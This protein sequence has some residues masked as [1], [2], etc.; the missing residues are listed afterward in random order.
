MLA[1]PA[2]AATRARCDAGTGSGPWS[3]RFWTATAG[4]CSARCR[5]RSA[6]ARQRAA[7]TPR[8]CSTPRRHGAWTGTFATDD[9]D[10]RRLAVRVAPDAHGVIALRV[11]VT[12]S[13]R[14]RAVEATG[15]AFRARPGERYLG[16]G[17]RSNSVDQRGGEVENYVAEGPYEEDDQ[18]DHP[19]VRAR[20]GLPPAP[21]RHLLP[22]ALAALHRRL[23]RAGGRPRDELLPPRPGRERGL[24]RGGGGGAPQPARVRR[25]AP[26]RRPAPLHRARRPPARG[27][28][29]VLLRAL[30]PARAAPSRRRCSRGC[31][32]ATRRCPWPRPTPTTCPCADQTGR[33]EAERARVAGFHDAGLAVTTYFNPMICTT[34]PRYG[35]A[36]ADGALVKNPAGE[37]YVYRY[38]TLTTLRRRRSST[39]PARAGRDLYGQLLREA[40]ADG[41]DGWMED[42]GEYTPLDARRGRRHRPAPALHNVYPRQ[43]HC[44]AFAGVAGCAARA[45]ALRRARAGPAARAARRSCGAATRRSGWGFDGLRSVVT[46]GLTMGLS[47]VSTWGSDIGGFFALFG[48]RLDPGAAGPL[49]RGGRGVR[50]DAHAGQRDQHPGAAARP[51][52]GR[53]GAAALAPLGQAA[54]AALPLPRRG[55]RGV[56]PQRS[57]DHAPPRAGL[58]RTTRARPRW[59]TPSSSAPTCWPRRCSTRARDERSVYLPRGDWVDLWRSAELPRERRR[60][61]PRPR[62]RAR[63]GRTV[64][65]PAPLA[66]LPLLA[67]AGTLLSLL[68]AGRGHARL[69]RRRRAGRLAR[70][71]APASACCSPSRAGAPR[72][73]SRTAASCGRARSAG[74]WQPRD[75][76]RARTSAGRFRRRSRRCASRS[77]PCSRAARRPSAAGGAWSYD[78]GTGV[79]SARFGAR[80]GELVARPC[81]SAHERRL[82]VR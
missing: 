62:A 17:E 8:A 73:G 23:R 76:R 14:R 58:S 40:M 25:P 37:P 12:G 55:R 34:H 47:G 22:G 78:A 11:E 77:R 66:E 6:S 60:P 19:G 29:A 33:E 72:R 68:P 71:S 69:V 5:A 31:A 36:A 4:R 54:H 10:G 38:S 79:L 27:R 18:R 32:S 46:N 3:L 59:R 30:V 80:R 67:R 82:P 61:R 20:L 75:P 64:T 15:I 70:R 13:G 51:D 43:Y 50:R 45:R 24:E 42:F 65:V 56:P 9:P 21:R 41:H 57:A 39:S 52:L 49:D 7:S 53:R 74:R 2:A 44:G 28:R 35:E 26:G 81:A 48:N 1:P 63:G 16:F